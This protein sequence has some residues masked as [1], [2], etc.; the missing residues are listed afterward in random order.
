[1]TTKIKTPNLAMRRC[2]IVSDALFTNEDHT[3]LLV[4]NHGTMGTQNIGKPSNK[5]NKGAA[6]TTSEKME[7][8]NVID[9]C[10]AKTNA[11]ST[12]FYI[13]FSMRFAP[14]DVSYYA[15][16]SDQDGCVDWGSEIAKFVGNAK[17]SNN[18]HLLANRYARNILNGRWAWRNRTY[19][20]AMTVSVTCNDTD[21]VTAVNALDIPTEH[22]D[23]FSPPELELGA[24][25][26]SQLQQ[27]AAEGL[28]ITAAVSF[29]VVGSFEVFPS[30]NR[31]NDAKKSLYCVNRPKHYTEPSSTNPYVVMGQA[32]FRD[33]KISNAIRTVDVEYSEYNN[34][35]RSI[36]IELCGANSEFK[37][38]FRAPKTHQSAFDLITVLNEFNIESKEALFMMAVL[39]RGGLIT[40]A[41]Q[42]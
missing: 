29:G 38:F 7:V 32:A 26:L 30:Q 34:K 35:Q 11:T 37:Q 39:I 33:Q 17:T 1:M 4:Y 31:T 20:A 12:K 16:A 6:A 5:N 36:P 41:K 14:I 28:V 21:V 25:I 10:T 40:N 9:S 22:F 24:L 13:K 19:A 15:N 2:M 27:P 23:N 18:L 8:M 42:P 3:P